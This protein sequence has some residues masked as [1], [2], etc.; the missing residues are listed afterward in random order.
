MSEVKG[1]DN[2]YTMCNSFVIDYEKD[3][4]MDFLA[5]G[6]WGVYGDEGKKIIIKKKEE[7]GKTQT[8]SKPVTRGQQSVANIIK[9]IM[10]EQ[11]IKVKNLFLAGDNIYQKSLEEELQ[12][13]YFPFKEEK[14]SQSSLEEEEKQSQ[15]SLEKQSQSSL[16]EEEEKQ[17]QSSLEEEEEEKEKFL[18]DYIPSSNIKEQIKK[19][20][21]L[22][23]HPD[24]ENYYVIAG[25]HD[26]EDCDILKEEMGNTSWKFPNIFYSMFYKLKSYNVNV[27]FIDTNIFEYMEKGKREEDMCKFGSVSSL[28]EAQENCVNTRKNLP[29][30]TWRI[31]VGHIPYKALGHKHKKCIVDHSTYMEPLFKAYGP[32]VYISADEHNQQFLTEIINDKPTALVVAGSGGTA[33]DDVKICNPNG[34]DTITMGNKQIFVPYSSMDFGITLFKV[35]ADSITIDYYTNKIDEQKN[36]N[37]EKKFNV[38]VLKNRSIITQ[39]INE[40]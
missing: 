37:I 34:V 27:M 32:H 11:K 28:L 5:V 7:N 17:S 8:E 12:K 40:N 19:G 36:D 20:F 26:V 33:L 35:T 31:M 25:N 23:I 14:Q 21:N 2:K 3:E 10:D 24:I 22:F 6:C 16:E 18:K 30:N 4:T 9:H 39:R 29:Q 13:K 15:S 1:D 38:K